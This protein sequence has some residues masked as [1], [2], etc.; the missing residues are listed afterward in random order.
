MLQY[1]YL[2]ITDFPDNA[3]DLSCVYSYDSI[4]IAL[5]GQFCKKRNVVSRCFV[6]NEKTAWLSMEGTPWQV[7]GV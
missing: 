3:F 2:F 6:S 4:N 5:P 1:M 7:R